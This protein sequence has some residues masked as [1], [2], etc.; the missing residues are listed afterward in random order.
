MAGRVMRHCRIGMLVAFCCAAP[1]QLSAAPEPPPLERGRE[2]ARAVATVT[3]TAVSPLLGVCALGA[4]SYWKTPAERRASLPFYCAPPFWISLLVL[5]TLVML[6]DTVGAAV[7]F[8]KKPLDAIEI[9][10]VDKAAFLFAVLPVV[11]REAAAISAATAP[12]GGPLAGALPAVNAASTWTAVTTGTVPFLLAAVAFIVWL[13]CHALDVFAL[14]SPIPW[15]DAIFKVC[16][17]GILLTVGALAATN[18]RVAFGLSVA[19]IAICLVCFFWALRLAIFGVV[20]AWD[21]LCSHL[22]R[23]RHDPTLDKE[24]LGFTAYAVG[25]LRNR[26]FG[27]LRRAADGTLEFVH[28]P[29]GIGFRSAVRLL[30]PEKYE[31]SRGL[32]FPCVLAPGKTGRDYRFQ[33]RLLPRY[34]GFEGEVREVLGLS[35]VRDLRIPAE[36]HSAWN[37]LRGTVANSKSS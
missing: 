12:A 22:L 27:A 16:R 1:I 35:R 28:R 13:T 6:K 11:W 9:L 30:S 33:F 14:L 24:V 25:G 29:A 10:V 34:T 21:V 36:F 17:A 4:Y 26:T 19:I 20:F 8:L 2:V 37:W 32:F 3:G 7:P 18:P 5:L 23:Q 15:L 31:V